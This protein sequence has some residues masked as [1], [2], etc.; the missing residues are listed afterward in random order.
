MNFLSW[1]L[2]RVMCEFFPRLSIPNVRKVAFSLKF[3]S[4]RREKDDML[5]I[6]NKEIIDKLLKLARYICNNRKLKRKR[7]MLGI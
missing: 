5:F 3:E 7:I 6:W 1:E 2:Q 4:K